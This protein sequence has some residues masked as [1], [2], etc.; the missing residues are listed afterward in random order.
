M[1][2][3]SEDIVSALSGL[4]EEARAFALLVASNGEHDNIRTAL[5]ARMAKLL[6]TRY[7]KVQL[8]AIKE[9][10]QICF[11][12]KLKQGQE[13]EQRQVIGAIKARVLQANQSSS[14]ESKRTYSEII[15]SV[16]KAFHRWECQIQE[17]IRNN[18]L[19]S[20]SI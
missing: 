5:V 2:E 12:E 9:V 10:I 7:P 19:K 18:M 14:Y 17:S 16:M 15:N 3:K 20:F 8:K 13:L 1:S 6:R 4:N 11:D